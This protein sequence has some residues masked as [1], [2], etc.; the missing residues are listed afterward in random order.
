MK[1]LAARSLR[2]DALTIPGTR[3]AITTLPPGYLAP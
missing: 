3:S 2:A 1:E